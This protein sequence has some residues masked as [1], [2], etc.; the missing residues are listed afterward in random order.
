L[1]ITLA[2]GL[3]QPHSS[4]GLGDV[5]LWKDMGIISN[6]FFSVFKCY[7]L[8]LRKLL[9]FVTASSSNLRSG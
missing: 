2:Q 5:C 9:I 1:P 4:S 6:I 3:E 7:F 8:P